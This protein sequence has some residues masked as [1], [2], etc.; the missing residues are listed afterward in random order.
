MERVQVTCRGRELALI[1][2]LTSSGADVTTITE[3]E[4]RSGEFGVSGYTT[5]S[6]PPNAGG[7]TQVLVLVKN[8]HAV[9]ANVNVM[10]DIMDPA[11]QSFGCIS[12]TTKSAA[13]PWAPL[14]WG[15]STGSGLPC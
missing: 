3:C 8:D 11:I 6:P 12:T 2:I 1:N 5:F 10:V 9:R 4:E 13:Q 7:K 14:S 15:E